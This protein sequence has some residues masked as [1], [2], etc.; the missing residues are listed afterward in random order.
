MI[1][2][3]LCRAILDIA[4]FLEFSEEGVVDADAAISAMEQLASELQKMP[5]HDKDSLVKCWHRLAEAYGER[6]QFVRDLPEALG[7][8]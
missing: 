6:A 3:N 5:D 4:I 7:L 1:N 8:R 2:E